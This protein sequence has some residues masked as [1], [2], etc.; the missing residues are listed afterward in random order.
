MERDSVSVSWV[1]KT[2]TILV[3][4]GVVAVGACEAMGVLNLIP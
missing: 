4:L 3:I 1:T 2:I